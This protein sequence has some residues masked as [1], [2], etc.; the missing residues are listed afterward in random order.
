MYAL[1]KLVKHFPNST[2][3]ESLSKTKSS[4]IKHFHQNHVIKKEEK[5]FTFIKLREGVWIL[6]DFA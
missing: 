1:L 4:L 5:N 2:A 6:L 3:L